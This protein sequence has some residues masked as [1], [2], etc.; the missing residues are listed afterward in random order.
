M[1]GAGDSNIPSTRRG[2]EAGTPRPGP[3]LTPR[4]MQAGVP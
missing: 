3:S 1:G 2:F 4:T